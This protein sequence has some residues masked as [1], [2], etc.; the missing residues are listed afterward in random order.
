MLEMFVEG[1]ARDRLHDTAP[2]VGLAPGVLKALVF[3]QPGVGTRLGDLADRWACD[4]SYVTT[5]AD[6]LQERGLA[7]RV[8]HPTDRRVKTLVLTA[9]GTRTRER[10]FRLL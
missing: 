5:V 2:E 6:A 10:A 4:A 9:K 7:K 1:E 3:L 8:P